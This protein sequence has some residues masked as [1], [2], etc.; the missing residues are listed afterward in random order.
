MVQDAFVKGFVHLPS[1]R[2]E[3]PFVVWFT[4][5]VVNGCLDV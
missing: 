4:R 2:Q 3:L 1:F 5:I